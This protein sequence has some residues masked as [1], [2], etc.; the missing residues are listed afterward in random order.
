VWSYEHGVFRT[1]YVTGQTVQLIASCDAILYSGL[2]YSFDT[3][4][5]ISRR[6]VMKMTSP[7]KWTQASR[8]VTIDPFDGA[9]ESLEVE[10]CE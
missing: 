4:R 3:G 9:M 5:L 8:Y 1:N 6:T 7:D 2:K 10:G